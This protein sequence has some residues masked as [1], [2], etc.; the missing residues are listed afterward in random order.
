MTP[1]RFDDSHQGLYFI[2]YKVKGLERNL[3]DPSKGPT[4]EISMFGER[5][6]Q[7]RGWWVVLI[8]Q[9]PTPEFW[10]SDDFLRSHTP[11]GR[12]SASCSKTK[13]E[14]VASVICAGVSPTLPWNNDCDTA[15]QM[16]AQQ[17]SLVLLPSEVMP[18]SLI[19]RYDDRSCGC[20]CLA[21]PVPPQRGLLAGEGANSFIFPPSP[22]WSTVVLSAVLA[23]P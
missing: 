20:F 10:K 9:K 19:H 5:M 11:E 16:A 17:S 23:T 15:S 4:L 22:R 14:H 12:H 2:I 13:C 6:G 21:S 7:K 1:H 3:S 8:L 18:E